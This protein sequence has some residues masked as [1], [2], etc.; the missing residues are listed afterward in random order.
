MV[1]ETAS[2]SPYIGERLVI[3]IVIIIAVDIIW[4]VFLDCKDSKKKMLTVRQLLNIRTLPSS[5][6][7]P[8][9]LLA[10]VL[11]AQL[12]HSLV[13]CATSDGGVLLMEGVH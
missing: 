12:P 2:L 6:P 4:F 5:K 13:K 1:A 11:F 7:N 8:T 10:K 3:V 9:M